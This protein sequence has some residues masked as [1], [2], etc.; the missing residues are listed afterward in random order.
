MIRGKNHMLNQHIMH[1]M[2]HE[3]LLPRIASSKYWR[4]MVLL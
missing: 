3:L 1:D 4:Y 2:L